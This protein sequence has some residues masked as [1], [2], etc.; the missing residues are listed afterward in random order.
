MYR[1]SF[2]VMEPTPMPAIDTVAPSNGT[3]PSPVTCPVIVAP[4]ANSRED[5]NTRSAPVTSRCRES[6]SERMRYISF[7]NFDNECATP[8]VVGWNDGDRGVV[9]RL[10][11]RITARNAVADC[12]PFTIAFVRN[13]STSRD[14]AR[15]SHRL[16]TTCDRT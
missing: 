8:A 14:L 16:I 7:E 4:C 12:V 3:P 2:R 15:D 13:A 5:A 6:R 11:R 9:V 1:P 10:M